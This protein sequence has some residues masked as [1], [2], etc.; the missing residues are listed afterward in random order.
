MSLAILRKI[1]RSLLFVISFLALI[2]AVNAQMIFEDGF[3]SGSLDTTKWYVTWWTTH[4]LPDGIKP[5]IVTSPV[6][7]GKY[8][9][10]MSVVYRWHEVEDY[11]RTE[12]QSRRN[13]NGEHISFFDVNGREYWIGFSSY[14]PADW[15]VDTAEELIFQLHGNSG[16]RSPPLGLYINADEWYWYNRWQPDPKG[17]YSTAGEKELW[18]ERYEKGIWVDWVIHAVWSYKADG[19][20]EIYKDGHSIARYNGPNCYNDAEGMRGIQTGIYKWPWLA[21][22]TQVKERT[23]YLDEFKVGGKNSSY[24][25][26]APNGGR[27]SGK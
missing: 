15:A 23:V 4:Q 10:K 16:D 11:N 26:V 20:L 19:F 7:S 13:D 1:K 12:L 2:S 14:L 27:Q 18:R 5:E 24:D 8:A 22:P 17:K 25:E 21:G 3:E 9:V 6:R